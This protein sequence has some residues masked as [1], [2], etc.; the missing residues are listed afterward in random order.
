[1]CHHQQ[2]RVKS[3][4][5]NWCLQL[6][7]VTDTDA[8]C[9]LS[10]GAIFTP[11]AMMMMNGKKESNNNNNVTATLSAIYMCVYIYTRWDQKAWFFLGSE[12]ETSGA[13]GERAPQHRDW[14]SIITYM[15]MSTEERIPWR[16]SFGK[17]DIHSCSSNWD[18][19]VIRSNSCVSSF[20]TILAIEEVPVEW[21]SKWPGD[22]RNENAIR[23]EI[24]F[25]QTIIRFC[26]W[27]NICE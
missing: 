9:Q 16:S 24:R 6:A 7:R 11:R 13:R 2:W 27:R 3:D 17:W 23:R 15:I 10:I 18:A 14:S 12:S 1:M 5:Q 19:G 21:K 8:T 25:S 20:S 26:A 22:Y 4:E